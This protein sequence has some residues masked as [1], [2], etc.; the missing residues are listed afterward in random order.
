[1][2]EH[3]I[4]FSGEMVRA[5][6]DGRKTQTRR[7]IKPQPIMMDSGMWYPSNI[8]GDV[9]N[10]RGLHYA[11]EKHMRKGMPIDFFPYGLPG[12]RL[13]VRETHVFEMYE[14]EPRSKDGRPIFFYK[15]DGTEWDEPHWLYPH[16]RATD[17]APDL[18]YEDGDGYQEGD[19]QCKW[20]P[21][22][23]MPRWASRITLEIVNVRVDQVQEISIE[24]I[25]AEG[26]RPISSDEDGSELYE[27]Y[28]DLWDE[29]NAK[30]G[31]G[32]D[33]NPWVWVL[34]FKKL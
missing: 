12:D 10:R 16:Y 31:Y 3:P 14:D 34:E 11:N 22:I 13:W 18:F 17:P 7:V 25:Y 32:W 9:K 26:C 24:D 19:P 4:L 23:H 2:N 8:P 21:S 20:N 1:M 30:R 6:L 15:G 5:I 27:W 28:S 33:I 29:L